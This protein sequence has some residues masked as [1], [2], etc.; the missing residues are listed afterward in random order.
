MYG[1]CLWAPERLVLLCL[2]LT[3]VVGPTDVSII[4]L[5]QVKNAVFLISQW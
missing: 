4:C 1:S 5:L 3:G 2:S